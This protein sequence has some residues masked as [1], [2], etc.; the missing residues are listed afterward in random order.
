MRTFCG[1]MVLAVGLVAWAVP[2]NA[3]PIGVNGCAQEP[4]EA[5]LFVCDLF[6]DYT[7]TGASEVNGGGG[8]LVGY[9]FLLNQTAN[10]I[11]GFQAAD[12][13]HILVIHDALLQLFSNNTIIGSQFG[14]IFE[15]ARTAAAI[16]DAIPTNGQLAGCPEIFTGV[17]NL[18][19]VGY[20]A[21]ADTVTML[22]DWGFSDGSAGAD[23]LNIHTALQPDV[24]PPPPP[25]PTGVPEP[26]TLSLFGLASASLLL[27]RFRS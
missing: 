3:A 16:D 1:V 4:G 20:C 11:D 25:P 15:A 10:L 26:A 27:R 8:Y 21:T 23:L 7:T 22:V 17:P 19:G 2:S 6:A 18:A 14:S 5:G 24:E 9:T 12:V 13:A